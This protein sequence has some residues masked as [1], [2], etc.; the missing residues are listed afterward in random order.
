MFDK[1]LD[2]E[3]GECVD[4]GRFVFIDVCLR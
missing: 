4:Q 3:V 1:P 2:V